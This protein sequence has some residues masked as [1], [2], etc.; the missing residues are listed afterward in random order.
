VFEASGVTNLENHGLDH[1][2]KNILLHLHL[3]KGHTNLREME[4]GEG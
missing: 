2:G 3:L 1:W 4:K